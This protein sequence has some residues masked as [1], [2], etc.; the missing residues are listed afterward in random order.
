MFNG[1]IM[2]ANTIW[3]T[4]V[5]SNATRTMHAYV[6]TMNALGCVLSFVENVVQSRVRLL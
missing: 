4:V 2:V 6:H 3:R 1:T 5:W